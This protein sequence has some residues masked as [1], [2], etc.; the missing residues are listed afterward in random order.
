MKKY[1][2]VMCEMFLRMDIEEG[3]RKSAKR[4][5]DDDELHDFVWGEYGEEIMY[6]VLQEV[7]EI[8]DEGDNFEECFK[9]YMEYVGYCYINIKGMELMMIGLWWFKFMGNMSF[10]SGRKISDVIKKMLKV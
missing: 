6:K 8:S 9:G 1:E 4:G 7:Y 5:M 3:V 2:T 10:N